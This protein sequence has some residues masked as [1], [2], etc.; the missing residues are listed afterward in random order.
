MKLKLV[1]K[2]TSN[3]KKLKNSTLILFKIVENSSAL[4][5]FHDCLPKGETFKCFVNNC[6]TEFKG[7]KRCF[8]YHLMRVHY[9]NDKIIR[10]F[11]AKKVNNLLKLNIKSQVEQITNLKIQVEQIIITVKYSFKMKRVKSKINL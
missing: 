6:D 2:S 9:N 8:F 10:I 11:G 3:V 1:L 5:L 4:D 7:R